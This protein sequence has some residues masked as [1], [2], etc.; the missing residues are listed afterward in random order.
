MMI[1]CPFPPSS[2]DFRWQHGTFLYQFASSVRGELGAKLSTTEASGELGDWPLDDKR[3]S[4]REEIHVRLL[5]SG[6][7]PVAISYCMCACTTYVVVEYKYLI[8]T[9]VCLK[10]YIMFSCKHSWY[11]RVLSHYIAT[12]CTLTSS[13]LPDLSAPTRDRHNRAAPF[14]ASPANS[15]GWLLMGNFLSIIACMQHQMVIIDGSG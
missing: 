5:L 14:F 11:Y 9:F 12:I 1:P 13:D 8:K 6:E 15:C 3:C 10:I 4:S 2:S 7:L